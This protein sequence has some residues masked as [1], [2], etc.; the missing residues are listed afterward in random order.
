MHININVPICILGYE[1]VPTN[2]Y[3][4]FVYIIEKTKH[5]IIQLL[6]LDIVIASIHLLCYLFLNHGCNP[7]KFD[8]RVSHIDGHATAFLFLSPGALW[9]SQISLNFKIKRQ[10]NMDHFGTC[11]RSSGVKQCV[12]VYFCCIKI[13]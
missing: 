7:T 2:G 10:D 11:T 1:Y 3:C 8:V 12:Q 4:K 13:T 5:L 9:S 6:F